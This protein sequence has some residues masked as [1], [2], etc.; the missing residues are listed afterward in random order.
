[1]EKKELLKKLISHDLLFV[2]TLNQDAFSFFVYSTKGESSVKEILKDW[3][4][5]SRLD[6]VSYEIRPAKENDLDDH[7]IRLI[8]VEEFFPI[9]EC[10]TFIRNRKGEE[11]D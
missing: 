7:N 10:E 2:S 8:E 4:G 11:H 1:M 9:S 6:P 5:E 3:F